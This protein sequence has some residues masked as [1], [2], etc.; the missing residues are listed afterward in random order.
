MEVTEQFS[1]GARTGTYA[2]TVEVLDV[3]EFPP[4]FSSPVYYS[5]ILEGDYRSV[6]VGGQLLTDVSINS[7]QFHWLIE[8]IWPIRFNITIFSIRNNCKVKPD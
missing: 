8:L 5:T 1:T 6:P 4:V 7:T 3:N 2:V